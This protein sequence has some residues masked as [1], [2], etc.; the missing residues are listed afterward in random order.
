MQRIV[1]YRVKVFLINNLITIA[2]KKLIVLILL[3]MIL[4]NQGGKE[5][6]PDSFQH[7]VTTFKTFAIDP[8]GLFLMA[9]LVAFF[10]WVLQHY[11]L[12]TLK[13]VFDAISEC[14]KKFKN[15]FLNLNVGICIIFA[16]SVLAVLRFISLL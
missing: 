9:T 15:A 16:I 3:C 11:K 1:M 2:L 10:I 8:I 4:L 13:D 12:S 14:L 6:M 5:T 7:L